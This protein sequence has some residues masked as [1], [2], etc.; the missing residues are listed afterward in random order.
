[1]KQLISLLLNTST[2][3]NSWN[4]RVAFKILCK[5][6]R[7]SITSQGNDF[8]NKASITKL[9]IDNY[10][11]TIYKYGTGSKNL[12]FLHG[13]MSNS[14]H[15]EDYLEEINLEKYTCY[16]IDAP[17]HGRSGGNSLNLEI[18]RN[19]FIRLIKDLKT[20]DTVIGHS[21][22]SMVIAYAYL[23]NPNLSVDK[24]VITAAPSGMQAVYDF[25]K[26][27]LNLKTAVINNMDDYISNHITQISA[28]DISLKSFFNSVDKP[29]L[30]IHDNIDKIC[31]IN[32]IQKEV[33]LQSD[34]ELLITHGLGHDLKSKEVYQTVNNFIINN[35]KTTKIN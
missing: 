1:M 7:I 13:W 9:N 22:G 6:K 17:G 19:F 32:F 34:I 12:I 35:K 11:A 31:P 10:E 24:I 29:V 20:V 23:V 4:G 28:R 25:F 27:V 2:I 30:V 5:V 16:L 21:L 8:L 33:E 3:L 14:Q 26:R 15:W 18:Y